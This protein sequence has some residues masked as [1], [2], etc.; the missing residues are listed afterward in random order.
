MKAGYFTGKTGWIPW[1]LLINGHSG[2]SFAKNPI[3]DEFHAGILVVGEQRIFPLEEGEKFSIGGDSVRAIQDP[4]HSQ[5]RLLVKATKMGHADIRIFRKNGDRLLSI[6]VISDGGTSPNPLL[7]A[8]SQ[9]R[10]VEVIH[11]AQGD[12]VRYVLQGEFRS[13]REALLLHDLRIQNSDHLLDLTTPSLGLFEKERESVLELYAHCGKKCPWKIHI[14]EDKRSIEILGSFSSRQD[15][16]KLAGGILKNCA[17]CS[18]NAHYFEEGTQTVFFKVYLM[19]LQRSVEKKLG[20]DWIQPNLLTFSTKPLLLQKKQ[21]LESVIQALESGGMGR[22]LSQPQIAVRIPGEAELFA[23]GELPLETKNLYLS[24]VQWK[25]FGLLLRLKVLESNGESVRLDIT[26]EVSQLD[27]KI[28]TDKIPGIQSNRMKT[29]VD[30]RFDQPLL[31]SGLIEEKAK[32]A[33]QGIPWISRVPILGDLFHSEEFQKS[34]SE[35]AAILLPLQQLRHPEPPALEKVPYPKS[36][37]WKEDA[38]SS[39]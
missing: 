31:L 22:V 8:L 29:Q 24:Q 11:S 35:L 3:P 34:N 18:W 38:W 17:I 2:S 19:E 14:Q 21:P 1:I 25:N 28:A 26:T 39:P 36:W 30:A 7:K 23:G 5:D 15:A 9:L 4:D 16:K 27:P 32:R 33:M 10:E 37:T 20:N 12:K 6:E 13:R